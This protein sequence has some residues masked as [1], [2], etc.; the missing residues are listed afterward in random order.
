MDPI[1]P[2]TTDPSWKGL[3]RAGGITPLVAMGL[4][5]TEFLIIAFGGE[6]FPNTVEQWFSLFRQSKILGLIYLNALDIFIISLLG[7]LFLALSKALKHVQK[8]SSTIA[9]SFALLGIAVFVTMRSTTLYA[10]T[11]TDQYA[12]AATDLQR[13]LAIAAGHA[14]FLA[15]PMPQTTGFLFMT[16][17]VLI[18]SIIMLRSGV[19]GT[20]FG[21]VTAWTGILA[22]ALVVI[23]DA[24]LVLM[25]SFSG[26][27]MGAAGGFWLIWWILASAALLRLARQC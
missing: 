17:A 21:K 13:S 24:S 15:Y 11:L 10:L 16:V 5:V 9:V 2:E 14:V 25:P 20:V 12:A 23:D 22:S 7:P 4:I 6:P 26:V 8:S 1:P 18:N 19:F 27:L 3:Y